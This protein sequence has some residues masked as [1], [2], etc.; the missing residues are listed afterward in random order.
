MTRGIEEESG[1][2]ISKRWTIMSAF[3]ADVKTFIETGFDVYEKI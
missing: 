1:L 3:R 2:T